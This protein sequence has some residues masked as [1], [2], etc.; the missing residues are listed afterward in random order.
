[1]ELQQTNVLSSYTR[2][3]HKRGNTSSLLHHLSKKHGFDHL[4]SELRCA[5]PSVS[6]MPAL[7]LTSGQ[8][9]EKKKSDGQCLWTLLTV[10]SFPE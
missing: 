4:K 1:M 5:T 2:Y 10:E 8:A 3:S 7:N 6:S 9:K